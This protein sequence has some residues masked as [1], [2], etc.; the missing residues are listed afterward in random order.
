MSAIID[1]QKLKCFTCIRDGIDTV[2]FVS[3][4][5]STIF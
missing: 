3:V 1:E 5:E 4:T 2:I